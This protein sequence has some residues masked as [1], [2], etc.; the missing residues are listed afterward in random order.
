[1]SEL[2]G[3]ETFTNPQKWKNFTDKEFLRE[4]GRALDGLTLAIDN[5]DNEGNGEVCLRGRNTFMGYFKGE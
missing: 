4:T 5:P 2:S 1:M 3:P